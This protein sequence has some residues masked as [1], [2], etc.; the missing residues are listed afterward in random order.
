LTELG[1]VVRLRRRVG[2]VRAGSDGHVY[3][4]SGLGFAVLDPDAAHRYRRVPETKL[5]YQAHVLAISELGVTL[6]ERARTGLCVVDEFRAEPGCWRWFDGIGGRRALKPD[7]YVRLDV[8]GYELSAFIEQDMDTES[9]PT[10]RRKLD[11]YVD[12]WRTGTEQHR[13]GVFPRVWW[14]VPDHHRLRAI[15]DTIRQLSND[16]H[17]LFTIALTADAPDRLTHLPQLEGGTR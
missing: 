11:L 9:L 7:A 3:G 13:Y 14:L 16:A 5:A 15:G 4:L 2:G 17:D 10:I 6:T 1:A 12:Y 8:E